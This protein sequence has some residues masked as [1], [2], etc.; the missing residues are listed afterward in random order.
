MIVYPW[1]KSQK[2]CSH[3]VRLMDLIFFP[4]LLL[5]PL[6]NRMCFGWP[7]SSSSAIA[8]WGKKWQNGS[9]LRFFGP[10]KFNDF[11]VKMRLLDVLVCKKKGIPRSYSQ[12]I[13]K[14][15]GKWVSKPSIQGISYFSDKSSFDKLTHGRVRLTT[16]SFSRA[17]MTLVGHQWS[18]SGGRPTHQ[19]VM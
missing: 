4:D 5:Q 1:L 6:N 8:S 16:C 9:G 10:R 19:A 13:G 18:N 15:D 17:S 3:S 11:V 2:L 7:V 14:T 12:W